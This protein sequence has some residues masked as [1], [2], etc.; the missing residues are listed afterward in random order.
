MDMSAGPCDSPAVVILSIGSQREPGACAVTTPAL[1][2]RDYK[3]KRPD[4]LAG[5]FEQRL[6]GY[7]QV[8]VNVFGSCAITTPFAV[9][10]TS[11]SCPVGRNAAVTG[12]MIGSL[13]GMVPT[14]R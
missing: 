1:P 6:F 3:S 9:A 4:Q 2:A 14:L 5:P 8:V 13:I 7:G 11:T 10:P 12:P